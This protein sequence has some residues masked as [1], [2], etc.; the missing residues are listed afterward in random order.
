M[1]RTRPS[2]GGSNGPLLCGKQTT[3]EGGMREPGIA[4]WPGTIK[5]GVIS[6]QLGTTMDILVTAV[7][8]AGLQLPSD[9][10]YDGI[11]LFP[12]LSGKVE[13][14]ERPVWYYRYAIFNSRNAKEFKSNY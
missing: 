8:V 3:F 14:I 12:V 9:R 4:W 6:P 11:D 2:S 5:P 7:G 13:S 10:I 1:I